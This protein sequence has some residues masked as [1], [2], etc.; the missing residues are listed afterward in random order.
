MAIIF[1]R[2]RAG[3]SLHKAVNQGNFDVIYNVLESIIGE[4]CT[5]ERNGNNGLG[6][7]IIVPGLCGDAEE[8]ASMAE[9]SASIEVKRD[10]ETNQ[11]VLSLKGFKSEGATDGGGLGEV[12]ILARNKQD[13]SATLVYLDAATAVPADAAPIDDAEPT[14]ISIERNAAG[15]LALHGI[16]NASSKPS[17]SAEER[18]EAALVYVDTS[19]TPEIKYAPL[20]AVVA[21][22]SEAENVESQSVEKSDNGV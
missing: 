12:V 8:D 19:E 20:D 15:E 2:F 7:K 17:F 4:G 6:W 21:T 18:E 1:K 10:E 9:R 13:G 11:A 3:E 16:G 5:I 22:D 14:S